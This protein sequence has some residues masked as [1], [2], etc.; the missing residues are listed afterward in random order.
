M[1]GSRVEP[2]LAGIENRL[3]A[4]ERRLN[5]ADRLPKLETSSCIKVKPLTN[6]DVS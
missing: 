4:I 1:R 5:V 3:A 6:H 2:R